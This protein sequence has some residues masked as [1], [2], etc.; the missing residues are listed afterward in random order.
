MYKRC[1]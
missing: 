1:T